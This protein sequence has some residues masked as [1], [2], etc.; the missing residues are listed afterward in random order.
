MSQESREVL[1]QKRSVIK[2]KITNLI[3][4]V[5]P[6]VQ[7]IES[8]QFYIV[9]AE[10]YLKELRDLDSQIQEIYLL[11]NAQIDPKDKELIAKDYEELDAHDD[12]IRE[13]VGKL[14]FFMNTQAAKVSHETKSSD[15]KYK[16]AIE[17]KWNHITSNINKIVTN[18]EEA[19]NKPEECDIEDLTDIRN[20]ISECEKSLDCVTSEIDSFIPELDEDGENWNNLLSSYFDKIKSN[21]EK[22]SLLIK[23]HHREQMKQAKELEIEREN[24]NKQLEV[25]NTQ[26]QHELSLLNKV[27]TLES[28]EEN[29]QKTAKPPPLSAPTFDGEPTKW[30]SYWQQFEATIHNSKKLDNQLRMQYLLKSHVTKRA[31]ECNRRN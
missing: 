30:K 16:K 14:I 9:C 7:K 4:K 3:K 22:L 6:L 25:Q 24:R 10:H 20:Q 2:Q 28:S 18:I 15:S 11:A 5:V 12:R 8:S 21:Q 27:K 17:R 13:T 29:E 31:R 26:Q 19:A 1:A 23:Q